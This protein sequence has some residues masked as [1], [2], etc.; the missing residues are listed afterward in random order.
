MHNANQAVAL[1]VNPTVDEVQRVLGEVRPDVLQFHGDESEM[2]CAGFGV[3]Y[4]KAVKVMAD[5]ASV[6]ELAQHP[7]ASALLLDS[8]DAVRV[9]GTGKVF[10]WRRVPPASSRRVIVAGG[11]DALNVGQ[12]IAQ[13]RPFAV[14]VSSGVEAAP[15]C[16]DGT[17]L[18]SFMHAVA[19]ANERLRSEDDMTA[20]DGSSV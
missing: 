4:I 14:D 2:F 13:L 20:T 11:L 18:A 5:P 7:T 17:R 15:G 9:G 8:F 16:K 1:F 10:D 3:P 12:A 6:V 19:V